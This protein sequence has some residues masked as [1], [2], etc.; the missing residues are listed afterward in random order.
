MP[1]TL[2]PGDES[3]LSTL[4]EEF[5]IETLQLPFS[6]LGDDA[7]DASDDHA[8]ASNASVASDRKWPR[9]AEVNRPGQGRRYCGSGSEEAE[10]ETHP[11]AEQAKKEFLRHRRQLSKSLR[12]GQEEDKEEIVRD[13][14]SILDSIQVGGVGLWFFFFSVTLPH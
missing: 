1:L 14:K 11:D 8:D 7:S 4:S 3:A 6:E 9:K 13:I 10:E 5:R 2:F 12:D